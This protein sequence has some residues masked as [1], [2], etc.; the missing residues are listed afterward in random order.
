M[1][2]TAHHHSITEI[3]REVGNIFTENVSRQ[4]ILTDQQLGSY[5]VTLQQYSNFSLMHNR[6]QSGPQ[7][8]NVPVRPEVPSLV[9]MFTLQGRAGLVGQGWETELVARQTVFNIFPTRHS[10]FRVLPHTCIEGVV[11]ELDLDTPILN[12]VTQ[13]ADNELGDWLYRAVS[14]GESLHQVQGCLRLDQATEAIVGDMLRCPYRGKVRE[15]YLESQTKLLLIHQLARVH[16]LQAKNTAFTDP[17]LTPTDIEKLHELHQYLEE[18]FLEEHS[19]TSLTRQFGLNLFKLKYGFKKLFGDS[20][21][22]WLDDK[23]LRHAYSLLQQ[24]STPVFEVACQ[25]GYEHANNFSAAFK[26]KFGHSPQGLR[27]T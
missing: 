27:K 8:V 9:M 1:Q 4:L 5:A 15:M 26:R 2:S 6:M 11:V 3:E 14:K 16:Q 10:V 12:E 22:K 20:V 13:D 18:H 17:K 23:K 25:L 21:M 24:E 7:P 19:L